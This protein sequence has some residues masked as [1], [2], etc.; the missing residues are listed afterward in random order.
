M[1]WSTSNRKSARVGS[2][3]KIEKFDW[4]C[5]T[6]GASSL[7]LLSC[8]GCH[9]RA[10]CSPECQKA[11][12]KDHKALCMIFRDS[13]KEF[14]F[15][16]T[17]KE[18]FKELEVAG[19]PY[20]LS[21]HLVSLI[22]RVHGS[23]IQQAT[24]SLAD[25]VKELTTNYPGSVHGTILYKSRELICAALSSVA[26]RRFPQFNITLMVMKRVFDLFDSGIG[27][28]AAPAAARALE[29]TI[30]LSVASSGIFD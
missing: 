7:P 1:D 4:W 14:A 15:A 25:I 23:V 11:S 18:C 16:K 9:L 12:W 27:I 21:A 29:A 5:D 19:L 30:L 2:V 20:N 17:A 6:C 3:D 22:N 26:A 8:S 24:E 10:Y 28:L 13:S